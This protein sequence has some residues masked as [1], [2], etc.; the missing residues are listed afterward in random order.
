MIK[1]QNAEGETMYIV[2]DDA[3][4]P[5]KVKDVVIE[6][7]KKEESETEEEVKEEQKEKENAD[8]E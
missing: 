4:K 6:E 3:S 7:E 5:A 8:V 1:I 2:Q